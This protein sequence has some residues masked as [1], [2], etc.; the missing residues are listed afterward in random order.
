MIDSV[1]PIQLKLMGTLE[2]RLPT[3]EE[4]IRL[5]RQPKRLGLLSYLALEACGG[6][7]RRDS[8]VALF[9]PE[10]DRARARGS[11]R[12]SLAFL[13]TTL[14][15]EVI[16]GRGPEEV[17]LCPASVTCDVTQLG[18][19]L[20]N[21]QTEDA[22]ALYRGALLS[23]FFIEGCSQ[24]QE[25]LD[26]RRAVLRASVGSA[27]WQRAEREQAEGNSMEA[28]YWGKK[29]LEMSPFD[30]P[31]VQRLIRLLVAVGDNAGALRTYRG[32][33]EKL[34]AEFGARPSDDTQSLVKRLTASGGG[35]VAGTNGRRS[36]SD[37]RLAHRRVA[38]QG[39]PLGVDRRTGLD[40]RWGERRI[41]TERRNNG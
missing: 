17:S 13:R 36:E 29:A 15:P 16:R 21:G 24:F 27:A 40:R 41:A 34:R 18:S 30:E 9:W 7:V 28:A 3:G 22:I 23:G 12:Q 6:F 25:W 33:E 35:T 19:M 14:G 11:L 32:L 38:L 37:R 5:L 20:E 8:L 31:Q 10:S 39:P 4:P 2:V 26:R 1:P